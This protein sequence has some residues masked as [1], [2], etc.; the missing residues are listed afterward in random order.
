MR[1]Q[2]VFKATPYTGNA[3]SRTIT[4][5]LNLSASGSLVWASALNGIYDQYWSTDAVALSP[6][7]Y[8]ANFYSGYYGPRPVSTGFTLANSA[9]NEGGVPYMSWSFK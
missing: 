7:T 5:G 3:A 1:P 4:N 9:Y 2:D 6:N 8:E